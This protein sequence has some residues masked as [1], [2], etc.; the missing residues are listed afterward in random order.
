VK[1]HVPAVMQVLQAGW[2]GTFSETSF[3][4]RPARSAHQAVER[5]QTYL[6]SG[7]AV[8]VDI[9]LEKFFDRVNQRRENASASHGC[10]TS[11]SETAGFQPAIAAGGGCASHRGSR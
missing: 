1:P 4:F 9:D 5:A 7:H 11:K 8:V 10:L 2:D 3:G 6:A